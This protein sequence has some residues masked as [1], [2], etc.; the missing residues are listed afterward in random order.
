MTSHAF[1][2]VLSP[3]F[4]RAIRHP[5]ITHYGTYLLIYT[6]TLRRPFPHK[7]A[8][9]NNL[10]VR[11]L[12]DSDLWYVPIL[13]ARCKIRMYSCW[14]CSKSV[15][16][17]SHFFNLYGHRR[18]R[19]LRLSRGVPHLK[20]LNK[21]YILQYNYKSYSYFYLRS[22]D[23]GRLNPW[24]SLCA[25]ATPRRFWESRSKVLSWT[26]LALINPRRDTWSFAFASPLPPLQFVNLLYVSVRLKTTD[27]RHYLLVIIPRQLYWK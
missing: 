25:H 5:F 19:T 13:P 2:H 22:H 23:E 6:D 20:M 17:L 12:E 15:D 14:C 21:S 18:F 3:N 11:R 16:N 26:A 9:P 7:P 1:S 27:H 4:L 24:N 8:I 10:H